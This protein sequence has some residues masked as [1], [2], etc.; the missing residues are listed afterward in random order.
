MKDRKYIKEEPTVEEKI[1]AKIWKVLII[2]R[3]TINGIKKN[4]F[5][6][7]GEIVWKDNCL[8]LFDLIKMLRMK[9]NEKI[10]IWFN[11]KYI[12]NNDLRKAVHTVLGETSYEVTITNDCL[13]F[14]GH[15]KWDRS[16]W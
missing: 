3:T 8:F 9:T 5:Q 2:K 11:D 12:N 1:L 10:V 15:E 6:Y 4:S 14:N 13:V 7:G 16:Y